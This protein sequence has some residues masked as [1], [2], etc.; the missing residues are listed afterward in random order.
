MS[1]KQKFLIAFLGITVLL[2]GA[3]VF[4]VWGAKPPTA[5]KVNPIPVGSEYDPAAWATYYPLEYKSWQKNSEMAPSPTG[6][7]GGVKEQKSIKQTALPHNFKGYPFEK[8]Y[9]EDR[10]H[11]YAMEDLRTSERIGPK[12]KGAC[13]TCKTPYLEQFYKEMGWEYANKPLAELIEKAKH[14]ISCANCHDPQTMALRVINPGFIEAQAKRGIDVTKASREEMRSFVCG[15]CHAEYHFAPNTAQVVF[16]WEKGLTPSAMYEYYATKPNGFAGDWQHPDSGAMMLK[17]QHPDF[18]E[19]Q[20]GTHGKAGVSCADCHMPYMREQ[21]RKYT[22]HWITSPLK[23]LDEACTTCHNQGKDWLMERVKTTQD[24]VW[25]LQ[26]TAELKVSRAHDAIKKA[27]AVANV[28]QTE[29]AV[30]REYVRKAQWYWD[31]VAASNS[32]GFHNSV[33]ELNTLGQA[34]DFSALAIEAA[35]RAAN[36]NT[37]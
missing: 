2:F 26:H 16:P 35:N 23:H 27:A 3:I 34:I 17:A 4:R 19:W 22:S 18:E 9:T 13:I 32:M 5:M 33:Q 6:Y 10:G 15:Q 28:N 20:N 11:T 1:K 8:D 25:Q 29:L 21:G 14:E 7:G 31:Y 30:A 24:N 37:L 36:T 12:S